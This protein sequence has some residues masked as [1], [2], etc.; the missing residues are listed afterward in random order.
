MT[1]LIA[2]IAAVAALALATVPVIAVGAAH[3]E[4]RTVIG[5]S[6][7]DFARSSD[8][9]RFD[10]RVSHAAFKV[11]PS[12]GRAGLRASAACQDDVKAQAATYT[13]D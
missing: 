12:A 1:N 3:A 4:T 6:D 10:R 7:L 5:V 13:G 2:R 9:A 8:V 11:C